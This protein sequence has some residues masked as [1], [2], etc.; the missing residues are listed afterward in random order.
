MSQKVKVLITILTLTVYT[1]FFHP[2]FGLRSSFVDMLCRNL[3]GRNSWGGPSQGTWRLQYRCG[4][5][6]AENSTTNWPRQRHSRIW[7]IVAWMVQEPP[8]PTHIR[9]NSKG[10]KH[11]LVVFVW[12]RCAKFAHPRRALAKDRRQTPNPYPNSLPN[13]SCI[14]F[15]L[16]SPFFHY[17]TIDHSTWIFQL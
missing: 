5:S 4:D 17:S 11:N 7:N 15:C 2:I 6:P 10:D 3:L 8:Q 1:F 14:Y 12:G 9:A 13:L 16:M